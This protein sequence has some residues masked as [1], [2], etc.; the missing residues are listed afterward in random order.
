MAAGDREARCGGGPAGSVW[1]AAPQ[2]GRVIRAQGRR[3]PHGAIDPDPGG[4]GEET[5]GGGWGGGRYGEIDGWGVGRE[6]EDGGE[7]WRCG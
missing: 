7:R 6:R 1:G 4:G 3:R 2:H 5:T